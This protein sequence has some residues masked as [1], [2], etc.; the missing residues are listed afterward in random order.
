MGQIIE[1]NDINSNSY[2][3]LILLIDNLTPRAHD[4]FTK[5]KNLAG[6]DVKRELKKIRDKAHQIWREISEIQKQRIK[7]RKNDNRNS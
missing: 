5:E 4:F 1:K 7:I 3:E 6:D 2:N